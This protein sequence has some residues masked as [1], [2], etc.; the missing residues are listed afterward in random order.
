MGEYVSIDNRLEWRRA[1]VIVA[2][3][4]IGAVGSKVVFLMDGKPF[5]FS[6]VP[7]LMPKESSL[8]ALNAV[9]TKTGLTLENIHCVVA[10][11]RGGSQVPFAHRKITEIS[12]AAAGAIHLWGSSVRT[13]LDGGGQS[14]RVIHCTEKGRVTDFLWNDKCAVGIG[15]A[16][17]TFAYL[18]KKEFSEIENTLLPI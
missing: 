14:C 18:S 4:D 3:L 7:T 6:H 15:R 1:K 9:L 13:V 2:G 10:T 5:A 11:G 17:E 16:I 8:K 12:C